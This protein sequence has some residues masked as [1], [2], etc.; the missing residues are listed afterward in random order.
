MQLLHLVIKPLTALGTPLSGDTFFGQLCWA[1]HHLYGDAFLDE[2]L[3]NYTNGK[4]FAVISDAFPKGYLPRPAIPL[5]RLSL[6]NVAS[7]RKLH[8]KRIWLP[9]D[10]INKPIDSLLNDAVSDADIAETYKHAKLSTTT[11]QPHNSINRLTGTTGEEFTPYQ[12][13]QNW[14]DPQQTLSL[15]VLTDPSR[16]NQQQIIEAMVYI[17]QTGYG[18]DASIGLGKFSILS[19]AEHFWPATPTCYWL[20]LAPCVP[21]PDLL[22]ATET[23]YHPITRFG[24]H[25]DLAAK[26]G[27]PFKQPILMARTGALLTTLENKSLQFIGHGL[28]GNHAPISKVFSKTVHQGYA[29][30]VPLQ[31]LASV[32]SPQ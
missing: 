30:V 6:P 12:T 8:K 3:V 18:R 2:L 32:E 23:Y 9:I 15:Y 16:L 26:T 11:S 25:G 27:H 20:T 14:Y 28:G 19:H 17:G 1:L 10:H 24:R 7:D 29:P 4:P 31:S 22:D 21:N 5:S 13:T